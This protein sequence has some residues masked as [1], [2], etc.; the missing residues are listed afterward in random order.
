[1]YVHTIFRRSGRPTYPKDP[2]RMRPW[3]K[4]STAI[5]V[6]PFNF[7]CPQGT[8]PGEYQCTPGTPFIVFAV[9]E[10]VIPFV[11]NHS[12]QFRSGPPYAVDT[13][14]YTAHFN[15]VKSLGGDG[16]STPSART[17]DHTEI[18]LFWWENSPLK[19]NRIV[20]AVSVHTG[21]DLWQNARLFGLLNLALA[22]GYI[23]MVDTKNH[24]NYCR[25]V[26]AI[27][28]L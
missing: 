10:N 26:T 22:D 7:S 23:A 1:M 19:W 21:L 4:G 17:A 2:R 15:E 9:W 24:Y 13:K 6:T 3:Y 20:R 8:K 14:K 27:R 11:L 18:A 28:S 16:I 12:S 25:P 5:S